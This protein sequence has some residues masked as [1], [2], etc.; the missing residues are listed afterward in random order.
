MQKRTYR[1]VTVGEAD[2]QPAVPVSW[3]C[4]AGCACDGHAGPGG[5]TR[6][7]AAWGTTRGCTESARTATPLYTG[8]KTGI[9]DLEVPTG[10]D[11]L[12]TEQ[13]DGGCPFLPS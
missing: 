5:W 3:G 9:T 12:A 1:K 13:E 2:L 8:W 10:R 11:P 7:R 4:H 6:G